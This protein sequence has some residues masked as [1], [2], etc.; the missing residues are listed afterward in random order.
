M[1][2]YTNKQVRTGWC[3]YDWANSVY[4]LVI[5]SAIFPIYYNASTSEKVMVEGV[6]TTINTVTL[7]GREFI[8]TSLINYVGAIGFLLVAILMPI[9]TGIADHYG[10]KKFFLRLFSTIGAVSVICLYFFEIRDPDTGVISQSGLISTLFF[11]WLALIGF[12]LSLVF[13]N[14]YLP[15]LAKVEEQDALSAK[16]FSFGYVGSVLLLSLVLGLYMTEIIEVHVAFIMTGIWWLGFTQWP[17]AVL[18][19]GRGKY[20]NDSKILSQG[21]KELKYVWNRMK[22]TKRLKRFTQSFFVYSMGIQTVMLVAV[23]FAA[24]EIEWQSPEQE[25]TGLIISIM[26]IQ[27]IAIP[28]A[29][30]LSWLS[31][32]FGNI[33]A[34]ILVNAF[35][36]VLCT[37]AMYIYTPTEFYFMAGFVGFVMGGIQS[38]SRST[39][40]KFLP[41]TRDTA[42]YFSFYD[43]SEKVAIVFGLFLFGYLEE[44]GQHEF[45]TQFE[46]LS[47]MRLSI[48]SL[49]V[50]FL[51]GII[52]LMRVP[53]E[54]VELPVETQH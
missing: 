17:L 39:F 12:W 43:V 3:M 41:E 53:D 16:G 2:T 11:Y 34:L 51:A 15:E 48:V 22:Q 18:P 38:L 50:F 23:Y 26:L 14:S 10:R 7:F 19:K 30:A 33:K 31:N 13:Y 4:S 29:H 25:T 36:A 8:N 9:F 37:A 35:W 27:L 20:L 1:K 24:K 46:R 5:S 40:S 49:I 28:G 47:G 45:F 42:T 32:K 6:E 21:F 54:E 52:L 44:L